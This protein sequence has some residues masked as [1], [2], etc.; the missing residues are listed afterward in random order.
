MMKALILDGSPENDGT[1]D[2]LRRVMTAELLQRGWQVEHILLREKK[3]GPCAGDFYCWV[4]RP[5]VCNID[6]D[7][8]QLA[9]AVVNS[10]LMVWLTPVTFG[11]YSSVLKGVVDHLIQ[12][13]SPYFTRLA[14]ETHHRRRYARY[15]DFLL[16]G[17]QETPD[18]R[19]EAVFRFLG[20][21]NTLNFY[22]RRSVCGVALAAQADVELHS[23]VDSWLQSLEAGAQI[24]GVSLPEQILA[25]ESTMP[26]RRALLLVGSPQGRSSTSHALGTYLMEQLAAHSVVTDTI[27]I[28]P[29]LRQPEKMQALF[30]TLTEADLAVLAFP[31]YV[32]SLPAPAIALLEQVAAQLPTLRTTP[33]RFAAITNCGYPESHHGVAALAVCE[34]FAHQVGC[35]WAG[36]LS[37]GAG[38]GLVHRTPIHELGRNAIPVRL[39]LDPAAEALAE[40]TPIPRTVQAI[41][42]RSV[43]PAWLYRLVGNLGWKPQAKKYAAEKQLQHRP[44]TEPDRAE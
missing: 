25:P 38:P 4:R 14:G 36:G 15:P 5:G 29:A 41:W 28:H 17:W 1:G 35:G 26:P 32:D 16:A 11:G 44:Y 23:L 7:N 37:L 12:N 34:Q 18:E 2:R 42:A 40:G 30:Q 3:I 21:R 10:D 20:Y 39:A 8:R 24:S 9:A 13:I 19:A 33:L 43:I 31:L 6:D 22:A 27:L